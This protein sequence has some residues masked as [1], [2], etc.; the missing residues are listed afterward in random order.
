MPQLAGKAYLITGGAS[1][2]GSHLADALLAAG[3]AEVRLLDNFALGTPDT[4]G[5]LQA[6]PRVKL[7][8]GDVLRLGELLD[9]SQGADGVF[10]LAGFL[11]I[12]MLQ[13]PALGVQVNTVGLLNTL[14]AARFAGVRRVVFSSSVAAYGNAE[15]P[16]LEEDVA[17][18]TATLSPVSAVY[19]VSKLF[20]ESLCRLYAQKY[21]LEFNALRFA[22]VYGERQHARAVNANFIA[23]TWQRVRRGEA[24]IV[25]GDGKEVHDYI[26]VT[27][28]AE[29]CVAA[30]TSDK[31]GLVM[32]L[33]TAVDS[34]LT[35]VVETVLKVCGS[36][37]KPEYRPDTR[38]V[39]SAG[40]THLG[41]SRQRAESAIGWVPRVS[42]E[43]GIRRYGRWLEQQHD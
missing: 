43:E 32:N 16:V 34:T 38:A 12:P 42:L 17:T 40:G 13:N 25:I 36:T 14:E 6:E 39:R 3:A 15:A 1:L 33:A 22:S 23:E 27:D 20:G 30:M 28:I 26:Y 10:A 24:P 7:V 29:G 31:N 21:G 8:R 4:I 37:L 18:V 2:I 11:T 35:E 9:A 41:F 19:G 5:H